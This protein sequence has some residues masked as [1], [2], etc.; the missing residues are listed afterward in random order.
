M[1]LGMDRASP[2]RCTLTATSS[3][4]GIPRSRP[5]YTCPS[6]AAATGSAD[7]SA[8]ISCVGAP[9]AASM[10]A[11]AASEEK[12]GTLSCNCRNSS[13][14]SALITSGRLLSA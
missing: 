14:Y 2:G 13:M 1:S 3:P 8:K 4:A 5:L 10:Q 11:Y 6:E 9:R 12:G 7:S